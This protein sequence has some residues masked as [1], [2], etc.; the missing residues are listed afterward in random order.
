MP[1][2]ERKGWEGGSGVGTMSFGH[3]EG[4]TKRGNT[5]MLSRTTASL[6]RHD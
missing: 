2:I 4:T 5:R 1:D 6:V 3:R